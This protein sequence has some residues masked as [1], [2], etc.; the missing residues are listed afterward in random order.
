M[1]TP[2]HMLANKGQEPLNALEAA[3]L[4]RVLVL[5]F[6]AI[7]LD[8]FDSQALGFALP[9]LI[10]DWGLPKSAF[11]PVLSISLVGMTVGSAIAGAAGDRIGRKTALVVSVGLF[12]AMTAVSALSSDLLQLSVL[13]F[14][15]AAGL[16]G[17]MPNAAALIGET[18]PLRWRSMAISAIA[19]CVPLGGVIGGLIAAG[20]L[21]LIGW[22]GL[23]AVA[24]LVPLGYSAIL[25]RAL[26]ESAAF[27][28]STAKG[29]TQGGIA[30][31]L[32]RDHLA[33]TL[34][35]ATA[36]F[37]CLLS[38]YACFNWLPTLIV[39]AGH[40]ITTASFGLTLFNLGGVVAAVGGG[41]T[42]GRFGSRWPL[43]AMFVS[44]ALL[45][46]M[47]GQ[48]LQNIVVM[49]V[50]LT[51]MGAAIAGAQSVLTA[52]AAQSYPMALRST[53]IG[54]TIGFGR[55]GGIASAFAGAAAISVQ[56]G[57]SFALML[58]AA[59]GGGLVAVLLIPRHV[60]PRDR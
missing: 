39:D 5:T 32:G 7:V 24:G 60:A 20:L 13:R 22:R 12:G 19:V 42:A 57:A 45:S 43:I 9:A 37:F 47:L 8:G 41:W 27:A 44:A 52:V 6:L 34:A 46:L 51:A 40:E 16:G 3:A 26:P 21:P 31:L 25:W 38:V 55:L 53:G 17:A 4:V 30:A 36:F 33:H 59:A 1:T 50:V 29:E 54:V 11:A 35:L 48:V 23:F 56:G 49:L 10:A 14:F 2:S 18:T 28:A 58:S 15:A